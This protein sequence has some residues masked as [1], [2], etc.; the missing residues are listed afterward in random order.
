MPHKSNQAFTEA[1]L[2]ITSHMSATIQAIPR[3]VKA[4]EILRLTRLLIFILSRDYFLKFFA[5]DK[6]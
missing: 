1:G 2:I 6:K 5:K 3:R 4:N